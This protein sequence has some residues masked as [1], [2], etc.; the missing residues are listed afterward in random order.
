M[1]ESD[2]P[3]RSSTR[4]TVWDRPVRL[5]HWALVLLLPLLW[6]TAESGAFAWH[7]ALGSLTL[8]ILIFRVLWGFAG[9]ATAR[10]RNFVRGPRTVAAYLAT[11][12]VRPT[13]A[14]IG[15]NPLGGWSVMAMLLLMLCQVALG[16]VAG[17]PDDNAVGPLNHL[18]SFTLA[19]RS[20]QLH[21]LLFN[22]VLGLVALHIVAVLAHLA[23]K[24]DNLILPM[25]TG[26]RVPSGDLRQPA[27][28]PR[29]LGIGLGLAHRG[30]RPAA[31][32]A[33]TCAGSATATG[34]DRKGQSTCCC[35]LEGGLYGQLSRSFGRRHSRS[36]LM[37]HMPRAMFGLI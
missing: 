5:A 12:R 35:G 23:L 8:A 37:W 25:I 11:L 19:D 22:F 20:T 14:V 2:A 21:E 26:R 6:W 10:F 18:V 28:A 36:S 29:S 3:G 33:G 16:L 15:H 7:I 24:R 13:E 27:L 9:S 1:T 4:I 17:D 34:R 30:D 32:R 31:T